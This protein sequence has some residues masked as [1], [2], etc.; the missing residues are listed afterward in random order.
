VIGRLGYLQLDTV[1][2]AGARS[3]VIVLLSRR[4]GFDPSLGE[5]LLRPGA[6]L[7]EYRGHEASRV[8]WELYPVFGFR[9]HEFRNHPWWGDVLTKHRHVAQRPGPRSSGIRAPWASIPLGSSSFPV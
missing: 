5:E 1:S 9:R 4:E 8:S 2:I 6:P 7:F 3:H